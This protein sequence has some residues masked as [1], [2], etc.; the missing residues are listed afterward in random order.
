MAD[1]EYFGFIWDEN[2]NKSNKKKHKVSFELAVRIF[3][4]P[5]LYFEFDEKDQKAVLVKKFRKQFK[6]AIQ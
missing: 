3:N 5:C 6:K 4:D 2:K 1:K